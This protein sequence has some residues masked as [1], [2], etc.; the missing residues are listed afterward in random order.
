[1]ISRGESAFGIA[2]LAAD[3]VGIERNA[4]ALRGL[5]RGA[6]PVLARRR[7]EQDEGAA[8]HVDGGD[9]LAAALEPEMRRARAGGG[10]GLARVVVDLALVT[11]RADRGRAIEVA[12][13]DIEV[14]GDRLEVLGAEIGRGARDV[15]GV[16][17]LDG[18]LA[19]RLALGLVGVEQGRPGE[20]LE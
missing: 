11:L 6:A 4:G 1:T 12:E 16:G 2:Q 8:G 19:D 17:L 15:A 3:T 14:V 13:L 7:R 18:E 10:E 9:R 5:A 20:A